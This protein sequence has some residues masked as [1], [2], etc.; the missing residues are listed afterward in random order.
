MRLQGREDWDASY[1][2]SKKFVLYNHS[3]LLLYTSENILLAQKRRYENKRK[4]T[5]HEALNVK[6]LLQKGV[7]RDASLRYGAYAA[8]VYYILLLRT[9]KLTYVF[10]RFLAYRTS[11]MAT[12]FVKVDA[13]K[14]CVIGITHEFLNL[15]ARNMRVMPRMPKD[16]LPLDSGVDVA[17]YQFQYAVFTGAEI[18]KYVVQEYDFANEPLKDESDV[19][20]RTNT[21]FMSTRRTSA[22]EAVVDYHPMLKV[23]D[24]GGEDLWIR[25]DSHMEKEFE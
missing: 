5:N 3:F 19:Y 6:S 20:T 10:A 21:G 7:G 9:Q 17:Y 11:R 23:L 24:D 18:A 1:T 12:S 2:S 22:A 16:V 4:Y 15:Q 13:R 14:A 25:T 8:C